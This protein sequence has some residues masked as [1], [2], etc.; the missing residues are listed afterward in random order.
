MGILSYN[1]IC[2]DLGVT[3]KVTLT[4]RL[5]HSLGCLPAHVKMRQ[6]ASEKTREWFRQRDR[7]HNNKRNRYQVASEYLDSD[8]GYDNKREHPTTQQVTAHG[9]QRVPSE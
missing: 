8:V 1:F 9:K 6:G 5:F 4:R 7:F 3:L 2:R